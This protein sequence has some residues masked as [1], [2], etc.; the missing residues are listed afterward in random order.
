RIWSWP[1]TSN[2][3]APR[4]ERIR[5][6]G[7]VRT[8]TRSYPL[9]A[10]PRFPAGVQ[11]DSTCLPAEPDMTRF[12]RAVLLTPALPA[13]FV[14]V[15]LLSRSESA[16]QLA[17]APKEQ[18]AGTDPFADTVRPIFSKFCVTC[19]NDK[20]MSGGMTLE[21]Y[22]DAAGALKAGDLW[23]KVREQVQSKEIPPKSKPQPTDAERKLI[24]AWID[25]TAATA[26]CGL[27]RDPGRPTIRRLNRN[28]YNNTI[29]DLVGVDFKPAD[30]FPSD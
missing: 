30:D 7:L 24:L 20:K 21:P 5:L 11:L 25:A 8:Q 16:S 27:A 2:R 4:F 9:D 12:R 1:S 29:R 6:A 28:E 3:L 13:A 19:H 14:A 18:P 10:E 26:D 23:A 17:A 22:K 15:W